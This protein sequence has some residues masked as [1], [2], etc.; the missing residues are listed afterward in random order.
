M[1]DLILAALLIIGIIRGFLN[2]FIFELAHHNYF[3][4][5]RT[6]LIALLPEFGKKLFHKYLFVEVSAWSVWQVCGASFSWLGWRG[7][8]RAIVGSFHG[9]RR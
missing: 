4:S 5:I 6:Y 1:L 8:F 9:E 7:Y 2:G 3:D